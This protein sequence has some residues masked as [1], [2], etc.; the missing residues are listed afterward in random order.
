MAGLTMRQPRQSA[1]DL[2]GK[3]GLR[4]SNFFSPKRGLKKN[5]IRNV[6]K[7]L[8]CR[9]LHQRIV[10]GALFSYNLNTK[11][12]RTYYVLSNTIKLNKLP[13][14]SLEV[15]KTVTNKKIY[16]RVGTR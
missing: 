5:P 10:N 12:F 11:H 1:E 7:K 8:L 14:Q 4:K 13:C 16:H 6:L 9:Q 15:F 2:R 3:M